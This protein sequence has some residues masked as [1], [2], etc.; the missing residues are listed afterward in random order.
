MFQKRALPEPAGT[1]FILEKRHFSLTVGRRK[2][3]FG[4]IAAIA[5]VKYCAES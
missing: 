5:L 3:V 4:P 2:G 1:V